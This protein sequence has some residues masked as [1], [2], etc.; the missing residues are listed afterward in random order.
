MSDL[1]LRGVLTALVTPF[2]DG[3]F[4]VDAFAKLVRRQLDAG[5]HG[6][7]PCGT[8]GET[9][10]L[11]AEERRRVVAAVVEEAD[12]KVPVLAGAGPGCV[13]MRRA[14]REARG[15]RRDH[16]RRSPLAPGRR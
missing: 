11:S 2:Q 15:R 6:L 14:G 4:D 16:E 8:T 10:T 1:H 3:A 9:P 7:V 5:V 12:G 13:V